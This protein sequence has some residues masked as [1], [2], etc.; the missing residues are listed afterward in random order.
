M[1]KHYNTVSNPYTLKEKTE[2]V[3]DAE[4]K[5]KRIKFIYRETRNERLNEEM[6]DKFN[7][8]MGM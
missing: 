7:A 2:L 3:Q 6:F 4:K 1:L 8:W 5:N